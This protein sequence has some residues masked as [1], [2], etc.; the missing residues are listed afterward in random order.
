MTQ[1]EYGR[2]RADNTALLMVDHQTG[3][4]NGV[5]DMSQM[6]F[7]NNVFA[8]AK[9]AKMHQL[10][11]LFT[12]SQADGPNGPLLPGLK[13]ILPDA[14]V[15]HRPGEINAFDNAEFA[16]AVEKIGRKKLLVAG[17]STEVC[18]AFAVLSALKAGYEVYPV[19]DASGTWNQLVQETAVQCMIQAGAQPTD[20][21]WCC[22]RIAGGLAQSDRRTARRNHGRTFVLWQCH[23]QLLYC[24]EQLIPGDKNCPQKL[25]RRHLFRLPATVAFFMTVLSAP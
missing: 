10:P 4:S 14:P 23:R 21:D 11:T 22:R 5:A 18:V 9:V 15:I 6:E 13:E 25:C 7:R 12:T 3:I 20:L 1:Y 17:V 16:Q 19:I 8:L 2:L 24:Q